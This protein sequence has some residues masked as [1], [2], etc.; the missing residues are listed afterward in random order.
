MCVWK[1]NSCIQRNFDQRTSE[2]GCYECFNKCKMYVMGPMT[3]QDNSV[4]EIPKPFMNA[5][6]TKPT[7]VHTSTTTE[8]RPT[9]GITC[10]L[11]SV[12]ISILNT[13]F[14][15]FQPSAY[16]CTLNATKKTAKKVGTSAW[17]M[18]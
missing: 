15:Q 2:K 17:M 7:R 11:T 1:F 13:N 18:Q 10:K 9:I 12:I 16:G 3:M 14:E 8:D 6:P 4:N 5:E